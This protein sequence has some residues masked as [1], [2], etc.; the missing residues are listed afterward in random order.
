MSEMSI[1]IPTLHRAEKQRSFEYIPE[2]WLSNTYLVTVEED[3]EELQRN[4]PT[5]QVLLPGPGVKGIHAVRQWIVENS[6][7]RYALMIDDDQHFY[8]RLPGDWHLKYVTD[9]RFWEK[10]QMPELLAWMDELISS[11]ETEFGK[12]FF[13]VGL[14]ARQG[15]QN[16][17]PEKVKFN[18]RMNNTYVVDTELFKQENIRFDNFRVMEDFD[19]TLSFL[20]RGY[21]N[22]VIYDYCW[23]QIT[24]GM[25]G[26]CSEY[27]NE[28]IQAEAAHALAKKFP[29]YVRV[30]KKKSKSG[31]VGLEERTDVMIQWKKAFEDWEKSNNRVGNFW[32]EENS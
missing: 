25:E 32:I 31:W 5:A 29:K 30:K 28:E 16:V 9:M 2:E 3:V 18:T 19:V 6:K 10:D 7:T 15:N 11:K 26:G 23:G 20:T 13:A 12:K 17:F 21:P 1:Y 8:R 27:R 4:Y 14:S 22:A 24:S